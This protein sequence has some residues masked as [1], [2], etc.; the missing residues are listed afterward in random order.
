MRKK[1]EKNKIINLLLSWRW[2][3]KL[4]QYLWIIEHTLSSS[5][6]YAKIRWKYD[7]FALVD[8]DQLT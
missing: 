8:W 3:V 6:V 7:D 2:L 1:N 5:V 4:R